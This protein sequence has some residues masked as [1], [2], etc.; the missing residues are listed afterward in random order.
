MSLE[1]HAQPPLRVFEEERLWTIEQ[2]RSYHTTPIFEKK[3]RDS[4]FSKELKR[5]L[6]MC[7]D[8]NESARPS[9]SEL[10][11]ELNR[12]V[13]KSPKRISVFNG[14]VAPRHLWTNYRVKQK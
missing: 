6:R 8:V 5:H 13:D 4:S 1:L 14:T 11:T 12:Q 2:F 10:W 7:V 3:L 9:A